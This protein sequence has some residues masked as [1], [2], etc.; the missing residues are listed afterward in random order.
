MKPMIALL[1]IC[2]ENLTASCIYPATDYFY[3]A[4]KQYFNES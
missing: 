4:G 1:Q 2:V 3:L